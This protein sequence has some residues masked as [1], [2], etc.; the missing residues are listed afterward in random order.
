MLFLG[1]LALQRHMPDVA[2]TNAPAIHHQSATLVQ[3]RQPT[4]KTQS[5]EQQPF[6]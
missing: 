1:G 2:L 5:V 3:S 6:S 4:E